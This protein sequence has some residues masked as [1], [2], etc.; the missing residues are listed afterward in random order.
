MQSYSKGWKH[1]KE[2]L[3]R[4]G[5]SAVHDTWTNHESVNMKVY[6]CHFVHKLF[7]LEDNCFKDI[8]TIQQLVFN[9]GRILALWSMVSTFH[10]RDTGHPGNMKTHSHTKHFSFSPFGRG[11]NFPLYFIM[12]KYIYFFNL[13]MYL[14]VIVMLFYFL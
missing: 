1:W 11:L 5:W 9:H 13:Q 12:G 10:R 8:C 2:S 7:I 3:K 6:V 4:K 14:I